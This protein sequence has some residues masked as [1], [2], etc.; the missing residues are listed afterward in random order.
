[1]TLFDFSDPA[2]L[3]SFRLDRFEVTV[4]RFRRFVAAVAGGWTPAAGSGKHAHLSAGAGLALTSGGHEPGWDAALNSALPRTALDWGTNLS[5][6]ATFQTWTNASGPNER[7]SIN[8]VSWVEA[9]AFC[10]WDGGF[11][12]SETEAA[13]ASQ[14][15]DEQRHFPWSVPPTSTSA[16][17]TYQNGSGCGPGGASAVIAVGT[18]SPKGDGRWLQAD[19]GGNLR[20]WALDVYVD[21]YT[22]P[23]VDCAVLAGG[24]DRV[25]HGSGYFNDPAGGAAGFRASAPARDISVGIR[26]ARVP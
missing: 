20:E 1:V 19:L 9:Q 16:D 6:H 2:Q 17:C 5:C 8:C 21:G 15:G 25:T 7:S 14:G 10:I 13:Y 4:G 18:K 11:L 22:N 23:C 26:C 24:S 3:S 12:P